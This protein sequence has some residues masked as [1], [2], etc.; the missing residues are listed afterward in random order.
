MVMFHLKCLRQSSRRGVSTVF[1]YLLLLLI[2]VFSGFIVRFMVG[3][4]IQQHIEQTLGLRLMLHGVALSYNTMYSLPVGTID[5]TS[6][7][8][9]QC[10]V[11]C[12]DCNASIVW[13]PLPVW[14]VSCDCSNGIPEVI[15]PEEWADG[16]DPETLLDYPPDTERLV[17]DDYVIDSIKPVIL[18]KGSEPTSSAL[19]VDLFIYPKSS[20]FWSFK[21]YLSDFIKSNS[22]NGIQFFDRKITIFTETPLNLNDYAGVRRL[23][24]SNRL[25]KII[26]WD[27]D[28][29]SNYRRSYDDYDTIIYTVRDSQGLIGLVDKV[30]TFAKNNSL[31]ATDDV[32]D[33]HLLTSDNSFGVLKT[34]DYFFNFILTPGQKI[35]VSGKTICEY[36]CYQMNS[37]D[38]QCPNDEWHL[39]SCFNFSEVENTVCDNCSFNDFD[40][41]IYLCDDGECIGNTSI[42]YDKLVFS[43]IFTGGTGFHNTSA[44]VVFDGYGVNYF[45]VDKFAA[46]SRNTPDEDY[47]NCDLIN[48]FTYCT[49]TDGTNQ[50]VG[51]GSS[52]DILI[53]GLN[54]EPP[55]EFRAL[56]DSS[57]KFLY[58]ES[59]IPSNL[60]AAN[61]INPSDQKSDGDC[62]VRTYSCGRYVFYS[63][64]YITNLIPSIFNRNKF[65]GDCNYCKYDCGGEEVFLSGD[66]IQDSECTV[67]GGVMTSSDC[68]Y[69]TS[70]SFDSHVWSLS[71]DCLLTA[72]CDD[73]GFN[74]IISDNPDSIGYKCDG[75]NAFVNDVCNLFNRISYFKFIDCDS[76]GTYH[77]NYDDL[78]RRLT[79]KDFP[80]TTLLG[81]LLVPNG[82]EQEFDVNVLKLNNELDYPAAC[83]AGELR[84]ILE[85]ISGRNVFSKRVFDPYGLGINDTLFKLNLTADDNFNFIIN[86]SEVK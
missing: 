62:S 13:N 49:L 83:S 82:Q 30:F 31:S 11:K 77:F 34:P 33:Y 9:E 35:N 23:F 40:Y 2:A 38:N 58:D 61:C 26:S 39:V 15:N 16:V 59:S 55:S 79:I 37:L 50:Y 56:F 43:D 78:T 17:C 7:F 18:F 36:A 54:P 53:N 64:D 12:V 71:D 27:N 46:T 10:S 66:C 63:G 14:N 25:S 5:F 1:V 32:N 68:Y 52:N 19:M 76:K 75:Q 74:I 47:I 80:S 70:Q 69:Y 45:M 6:L 42:N 24:N 51:F 20:L 3:S 81:S 86:V 21:D 57:V 73:D 41:Q 29:F 65:N 8:P 67:I 22:V 44:D 84:V 85:P 72:S 48:E 4:L 28:L 60:I